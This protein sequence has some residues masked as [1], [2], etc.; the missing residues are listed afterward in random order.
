[1][2]ITAFAESRNVQAQAVNR[3]ILRHEDKFAGHTKKVG[4][5]IELDEVALSILD[6]KYPLPR[7]VQLLNGVDPVEYQA[8]LKEK[9]D[10]V[11]DLAE[12]RNIIIMMKDKMMEDQK[13]IAQAEAQKMLLEDK[14]AQLSVAR[15]EGKKKDTEIEEQKKKIEEQIRQLEELK[16]EN[17]RLKNRSLFERIFNK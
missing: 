6:E 1:M 12:A 16:N 5:S 11:S 3:Y 8:I 15:A 17:E 14:E 2:T 10:A 9:A 7:P 13:L 4:K